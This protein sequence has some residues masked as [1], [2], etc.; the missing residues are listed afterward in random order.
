MSARNLNG[1]NFSLDARVVYSGYPEGW[2]IARLREV[3][4]ARL[5]KTPRRIHYRDSGIHRIIKFRDIT[6]NTIDYSITKAA[7]VVN[8]PKAFGGL[9]TLYIG[10]VLITASAHS[11]DQI[12]KKC[13]YID[14]LPKVQGEIY[15]VGEL[16][17]VTSDPRIMENKWSYYW[18]LSD[19][20]FRAVQS[21]VAGVHLTAGRAQNI[22]IPIAPLVEQKRIVAKVEELLEQ[23]NVVRERLAK[24]KE[25]LKR[26]RQSV[27][28]A[29]FSGHINAKRREGH[30]NQQWDEKTIGEIE[31]FIG[32]GITPKG[33]KSVYVSSGI[34]FIRSQNV[35]PTGLVMDD[36]AYITPAQHAKMSR[37]QILPLDVLLN[38]TGA[39]IG[40]STVVP[41][42]FGDG[43]VNQHVCILRVQPVLLPR[44]LSMFF[45]SPF[46]QDLI[47]ETQGGMTREGLNYDQIRN[48]IVPVPPL[49]EQHEIVQRVEILFELADTI[50]KRV[51]AADER[52]ERLT[53]AILAKAFRGELMPTEAELARREDRSYEPASI[54]LAKILHQ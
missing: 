25:I 12:G 22:Q 20:G 14:H 17:S 45:N 10:D 46:G 34:P 5:G 36:I 35:Y 3:A 21:A 18:F 33:G 47:F 24:V 9:R 30:E 44:F 2:I 16:L 51:A 6:N 43:N 23:V 29:A 19:D 48:F 38:I 49:E 13:A 28:S 31:I 39:S 41:E 8:D 50:A 11:G 37:T 27:L 26:F 4:N 1:S 53:Q 32:S 54:L 42:Y 7:Y 40:R 52:A 15:F